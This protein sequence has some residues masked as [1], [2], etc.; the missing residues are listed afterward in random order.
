MGKH[1][2]FLKSEKAKVKLK[3]TKL[4]EAQNVTKTDFKVRKII[5]TEQLKNVHELG[6]GTRKKH[7]VN[8]CIARLK[9]SSSAEVI[10]NLKDIILYQQDDFQ[11]NIESVSYKKLI[12]KPLSIKLT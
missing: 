10:S 11:R 8:D 1:K 7:S 4:K 9:N 6:V 3:G 2:K 12:R 5:I